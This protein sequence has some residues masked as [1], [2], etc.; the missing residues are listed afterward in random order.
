VIGDATSTIEEALPLSIDIVGD[1]A[2][3][4]VEAGSFVK[5]I[6][7]RQTDGAEIV[8][9]GVDV[10]SGVGSGVNF[11]VGSGVGSAVGFLLGDLEGEG[12][13]GLF[14]G[15]LVLRNPEGNTVG[16][17]TPNEVLCVPIV[18]H[19]STSDNHGEHYRYDS[20]PE[21][22]NTGLSI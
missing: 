16:P 11:S 14:V 22:Y 5:G 9:K 2:A 20:T 8:R 4:D 19:V 1:G 12:V 10:G 6:S 7:V 17:L 13:A 21:Q 3:G 15:P 18:L